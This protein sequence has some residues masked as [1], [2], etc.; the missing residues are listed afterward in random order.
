MSRQ[1]MPECER[2][3]LICLVNRSF[4]GRTAVI[5]TWLEIY[6]QPQ[7]SLSLSLNCRYFW[8]SSLL[9]S[10]HHH[11][12]LCKLGH[13]QI[14]VQQ[15][16]F[17]DSLPRLRVSSSN[18]HAVEYITRRTVLEARVLRILHCLIYCRAGHTRRL[19]TVR[20]RARARATTRA[21]VGARAS[22]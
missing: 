6:L 3:D 19:H 10:S 22:M 15:C 17:H 13:P 1:L 7:M 20:V 9:L 16:R 8:D 14:L 2:H 18:F 21:K 12:P 11:C 5:S 4:D